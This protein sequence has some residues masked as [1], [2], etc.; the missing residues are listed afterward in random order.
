MSSILPPPYS[1]P[2][3]CRAAPSAP[4]APPVAP[5]SASTS[6][7]AKVVGSLNG[8]KIVL[9]V[10]TQKKYMIFEA[11]QESK[12]LIAF[13]YRDHAAAKEDKDLINQISITS[14]GIGI[15]A[16]AVWTITGCVTLGTGLASAAIVTTIA[17][18]IFGA[19][20]LIISLYYEADPEEIIKQRNN[21]F[22]NYHTD[23]QQSNITPREKR[24]LFKQ[25]Y[26]RA[27]YPTVMFRDFYELVKANCATIAER[28]ALNVIS[29]MGSEQCGT[30]PREFITNFEASSK[31]F[32]DSTLDFD[33]TEA[34][35]SA[36]SSK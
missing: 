18:G 22:A 8:K 14:F 7:L 26:T 27:F 30:K 15:G 10:A 21:S 35:L 9:H 31:E 36:L 6:A 23:S 12:R 33:T 4:L 5:S 24:K 1:Y 11:N 17:L 29:A 3:H 13:P 28:R 20:H 2:S 32:S 34:I 25:S 19:G 16:S